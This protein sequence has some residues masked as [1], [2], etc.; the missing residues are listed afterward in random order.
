MTPSCRNKVDMASGACGRETSA[1]EI[2]CLKGREPMNGLQVVLRGRPRDATNG[3]TTANLEVLM[4]MAD[5]YLGCL[6]N[7]I[8][9]CIY[10]EYFYLY[11]DRIPTA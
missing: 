7:I 11:E 2:G 9:G 8:N 5:A 4:M 10:I 1:E 3:I 6:G